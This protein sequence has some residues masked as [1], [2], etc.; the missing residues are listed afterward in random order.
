MTFAGLHFPANG[1][2]HSQNVVHK[3]PD[4][5]A[6]QEFAQRPVSRDASHISP[7]QPDLLARPDKFERDLSPGVT[8]SN[9]QDRLNWNILSI[10]IGT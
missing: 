4:W 2:I 6:A 9:H 1:H 10:A 5:P 8:R 7:R 3:P